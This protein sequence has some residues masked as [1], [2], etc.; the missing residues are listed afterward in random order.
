MESGKKQENYT[1]SSSFGKAEN[2][3]GGVQPTTMAKSK[4]SPRPIDAHSRGDSTNSQAGPSQSPNLP[5]ILL[6]LYVMTTDLREVMKQLPAS[7][8]T[9]SNGKLYISVEFPGKLLAV[10]NG[11][12]LVDGVSVGKLL[13]N[14]PPADK[15]STGGK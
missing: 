10:E 1:G 14:L 8:I 15:K 7:R 6:A 11:K 4:E 3:A 2:G 12:I 5:A 13:A 9:S